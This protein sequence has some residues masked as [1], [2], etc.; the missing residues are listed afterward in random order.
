MTAPL[1]TS[2]IARAMP[3]G[4][5]AVPIGAGAVPTAGQAVPGPAPSAGEDVRPARAVQLRIVPRR[6]RAAGFAAFLSVLVAAV[7]LGAAVLHTR[8]AERQ[9]EIDRIER[10]V[11]EA[12][13]RFDVLRR[14]RAELRAPTHLAAEAARLGMVPSAGGGDFMAVDAWTVAQAIAA[15]GSAP[16]PDD[17]LRALEP[18]DQ[19]RLVKQV[20][21]QD[22][23]DAGAGP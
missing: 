10:A 22:G 3:R 12:Q 2:T 23:I 17:A 8:L 7:M 18:L 1:R 14:Q 16:T 19:Y 6:R 20:G 15:T 11:A 9:L 13:E 4:I 5:R 21:V